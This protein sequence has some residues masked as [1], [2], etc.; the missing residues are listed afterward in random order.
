MG[1]VKMK[2]IWDLYILTWLW[3]VIQKVSWKL[4]EPP[5]N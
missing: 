1:K 2:V 4:A 5:T 3:I